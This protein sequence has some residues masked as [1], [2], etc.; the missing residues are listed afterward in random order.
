MSKFGVNSPISPSN[1]IKVKDYAVL[2]RE[3]I[4]YLSDEDEREAFLLEPSKFTK[5]VESIPLDI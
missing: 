5:G 2:Y 1:P 4:Y 3:R